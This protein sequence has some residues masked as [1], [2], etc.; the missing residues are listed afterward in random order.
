MKLL[1]TLSALLVLGVTATVAPAQHLPSEQ[2]K[3]NWRGYEQINANGK[4]VKLPVFEEAV[5]DYQQKLPYYYIHISGKQLASFT[6]EN[7]V[8]EPFTPADAKAFPASFSENA[9]KID[10]RHG[11]SNKVLRSTVAVLPVRKNPATGQLE[12]LVSFGYSY[13]TEAPEKKKRNNQRTYASNSVLSTGDS[14]RLA[15][16]K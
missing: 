15:D 5:T 6:L 7:P 12:K 16:N 14:N 13:T 10:I 9:P 1:R 4:L 8:Y 3:I 2:I 11:I